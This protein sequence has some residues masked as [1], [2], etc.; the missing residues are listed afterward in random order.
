MNSN[1]MGGLTFLYVAGCQNP[2]VFKLGCH[3][4]GRG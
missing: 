3:Q 2:E 1:C 4:K